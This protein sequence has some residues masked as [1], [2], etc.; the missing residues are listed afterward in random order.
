M[1]GAGVGKGTILPRMQ[2]LDKRAR[3]LLKLR[4][5]E[6]R[7]IEW[8]SSKF[9]TQFI[10][11]LGTII[12]MFASC[13]TLEGMFPDLDKDVISDVVRSKEGRIGMAVDACLALSN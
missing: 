7:S 2:Q 12:L 6:H 8:W 13:R 11:W 1:A 10:T 4:G 9:H 3:R 5:S